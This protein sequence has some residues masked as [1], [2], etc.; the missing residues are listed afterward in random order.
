MRNIAVDIS[1][2]A[3]K[4]QDE[5]C[6][7]VKENIARTISCIHT[8]LSDAV[9]LLSKHQRTVATHIFV[10]AIGTESRN[11]KPYTLPVQCL[12]IGCLKD[13]QARDLAN[14]VI[15]AMKERDMKVAGMSQV[16]YNF[17]D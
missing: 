6:D 16:M 8:L 3:E 1:S 7:L 13:Q 12:P 4:I 14:K 5:T 11:R 15:A 10:I 9:K 2:V 17:D